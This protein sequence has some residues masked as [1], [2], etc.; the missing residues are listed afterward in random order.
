MPRHVWV[1]QFRWLGPHYLALGFIAYALITSYIAMGLVG[2]LVLLVPL[3]M[4]H[5]SQRQYVTAT[6]KMVTQLRQANLKLSDRSE[7][8]RRLNDELFLAL[9]STIDLRDPDVVEHSSNVARYAVLAAQEMG[10]PA[11]RI[12]LLRSRRPHARHRQARHPRSHPL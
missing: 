3:L 4:L 6:E 5:F 2:V 1:D 8:V 7:A 11:D 10:L 12:E 9:A